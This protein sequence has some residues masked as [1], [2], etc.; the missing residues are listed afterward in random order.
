MLW[1]V[2]G[3]NVKQ[4][5]NFAADLKGKHN[6]KRLY[7]NRVRLFFKFVH[8]CLPYYLICLYD[9]LLQ[10]EIYC[11]KVNCTTRHNDAN[12]QNMFSLYFLRY[13][14]FQKIFQIQVV[15]IYAM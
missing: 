11:Y 4:K 8:C 10:I 3:G 7:N 15:N 2:G 14:F 12:N 13:L 1:E 6:L 5:A 9:Y